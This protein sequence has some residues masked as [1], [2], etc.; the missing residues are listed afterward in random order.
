MFHHTDWFQLVVHCIIRELLISSTYCLEVFLFLRHLRGGL[1]VLC[2]SPL[3]ALLCNTHN[4]PPSW[5]PA[6]AYNRKQFKA[7]RNAFKIPFSS[8]K[9]H[10]WLEWEYKSCGSE[11]DQNTYRMTLMEYFILKLKVWKIWLTRPLGAGVEWRS[12]FTSTSDGWILQHRNRTTVHPAPIFIF[13][14]LPFLLLE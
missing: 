10:W 14:L 3:S 8:L 11:K 6:Q 9:P 5:L 13:L 4:G 7:I 1:L 12:N 2:P